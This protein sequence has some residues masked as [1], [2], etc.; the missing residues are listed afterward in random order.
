MDREE[1]DET[2][3]ESQPL[4]SVDIFNALLSLANREVESILE[5]MKIL[6][7]PP[8]MVTMDL[9]IAHYESRAELEKLWIFLR[10]LQD[11]RIIKQDNIVYSSFIN[12]FLRRNEIQKALNVLTELLQRGVEL[13]PQT[14]HLFLRLPGKI[15]QTAE[16]K[17]M[18]AARSAI[19][20]ELVR[21]MYQRSAAS[22]PI[23]ALIPFVQFCVV[24]RDLDQL[25]ALLHRLVE[26]AGSDLELVESVVE[27]GVELRS[28]RSQQQRN[29]RYVQLLAPVLRALILLRQ[30]DRALSLIEKIRD[31]GVQLNAALYHSLAALAS[32]ESPGTALRLQAL[33]R[34]DRV[35]DRPR[36]D[37]LAHLYKGNTEDF[38]S[39][40]MEELLGPEL[41]T[42]DA[43][44]GQQSR[45][46]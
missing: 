5:R 34:H 42:A 39:L 22:P 6:R 18:I 17:K 2:A 1:D 11:Q 8:N 7:V 44:E 24:S 27:L 46:A 25:E 19:I 36:G 43:D 26:Q 35:P 20:P 32:A 38:D 33:M 41:P 9:L 15:D 3:I 30:N 29:S 14:Y 4:L 40:V 13:S 23:I 16:R 12:V 31:A 10:H 28:R 37:P 21:L 45:T